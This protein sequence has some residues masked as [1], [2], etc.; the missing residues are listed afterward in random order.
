VPIL[1]AEL[2]DEARSRTEQQIASLPQKIVFCR[3]CVV[4]NQRPRIEFDEWGV[5]SACQYAYY[6]H[7]V[8]DWQKR[9]ESLAETLDRYRL[10]DPNR[11]DV[12]VPSSGGKDSARVA[13]SLKND[14]GMN[15][16]TVTWAPF[17]YTEIG[18]RNFRNMVDAGF[19]N[20]LG[21]PDGKKHRLLSKLAFLLLG[22]AWQP[23]TYGQTCFAF[24][25]AE[26]F[27]VPLV[28]FGENGEAEYGGDVS[29]RDLAGMPFEKWKINFFKGADIGDLIDW[30][31]K[32]G[33][34]DLDIDPDSLNWYRLPNQKVMEDFGCEMCWFGYYQHWTPQENFYF[35]SENTGF[36]ANPEG[37]SEGTYSKYASLD[38]RLDGFHYYLAF[39][40]FG[41][42]RC[43]SDAAHEIRDG[44]ITRDEGVAL[45][46]RFDG[47]FP[48]R[49]FKEFLEYID[50]DEVQ[51]WQVV[52]SWRRPEIWK[53]SG[54]EWELRHAVYFD[55]DAVEPLIGSELKEWQGSIA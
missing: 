28:M 33:A 22:D 44:H 3:L 36:E 4:S 19:D 29:T 8:V 25:I 1:K 7:H 38:D 52:D 14:W 23:F 46:K 49:H 2:L 54:E 53:K 35:A 47:E 27:K 50:I 9:R 40:K 12:I 5:C 26:K 24:Q 55:A 6:K 32:A 13:F 48:N 21:H 10:E 34:H 11:Y 15:P 37:R 30:G 20:L 39:I 41:I 16:L 18:W 43:T 17:S 51:F 42:G 31:K 45:V